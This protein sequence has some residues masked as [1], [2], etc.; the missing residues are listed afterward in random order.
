MEN[1]NIEQYIRSFD[2]LD[3]KFKKVE[4]DKTLYIQLTE[5]FIREYAD[6]LEW[7]DISWYNQNLSEDFMR[8]F[9][10]KI[11]WYNAS[12]EQTLGERFIKEMKYYVD[13]NIIMGFQVMNLDMRRRYN[14]MVNYG[15]M[16]Q[17]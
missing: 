14:D 6:Y 8:E 5:N 11:D 13:W 12:S 2:P 17:L 10:D 15:G 16:E 7:D 4:I 1:K 3:I 9:R